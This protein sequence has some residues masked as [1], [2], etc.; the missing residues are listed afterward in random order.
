[1]G[2]MIVRFPCLVCEKPVAKSDEAICCDK[3]NWWKH[4]QC[5]NLCKKTCRDLQKTDMLGI[6]KL[7][8]GYNPFL[9][10]TRYRT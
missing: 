7:Y 5:N 3:C 8:Q 9:K 6:V 2:K 10:P 1:M 4:R